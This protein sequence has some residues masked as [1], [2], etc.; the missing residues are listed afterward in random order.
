MLHPRCSYAAKLSRHRIL[1]PFPRNTVYGSKN[2]HES[3]LQLCRTSQATNSVCVNFCYWVGR[4]PRRIV[5]LTLPLLT[6]APHLA[7]QSAF[8]CAR[9]PP[10]RVYSYSIRVTFFG[11]PLLVV[12]T[13]T[14]IPTLLR[15]QLTS[16]R[17]PTSDYETFRPTTNGSESKVTQ[18]IPL[19]HAH[20]NSIARH[21]LI[22]PSSSKRLVGRIV[23]LSPHTQ[24]GF[25]I[26]T[27]C[28]GTFHMRSD[29]GHTCDH[30]YFCADRL[31]WFT[32]PSQA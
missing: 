7:F 18:Y 22:Q 31:G 4:C 19:R 2:V 20:C 27:H 11:C 16:Y 10:S 28:E 12:F 29:I 17:I 21:S 26:P 8:Q 6:T 24:A 1:W 23:N 32:L 3:H 5:V 9:R 15:S 14:S 13:F 30:Q 25:T